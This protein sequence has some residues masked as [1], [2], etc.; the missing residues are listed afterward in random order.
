M[1]AHPYDH[2]CTSVLRG[3]VRSPPSIQ[4]CASSYTVV[5]EKPLGLILDEV[6]PD[7][8][9]GVEVGATQEDSNAEKSETFIGLGD[10]LLSVGGFDVAKLNFDSV[11]EK[12]IDADSPVELT[13]ARAA[14][15]DDDKPLDITPNLIKSLSSEDAVLVDKVV[16]AARSAVRANPQAARDL[17]RLLRIE[18]VLGAGVQ[19][20]GSVKVRFFGIFSTTGGADGSYSCNVSA[21]GVEEGGE[22]KI[23]KL[24]CA[25]DEGWGR[26]IDLF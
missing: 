18:I 15:A 13:M 20:D 10:R 17:G 2:A 21:T 22:V 12:L 4:M 11:M 9:D 6:T 23:T 16:R 7:G 1:P 3:M 8:S 19:K 25:K 5:L 14:Y 26:T 24:S